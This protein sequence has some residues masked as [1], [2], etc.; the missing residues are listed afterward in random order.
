M[1][2]ERIE[3]FHVAMPLVRPF[4]TSLGAW[5]TV[6]SV[7]V[8]MTSG[9]LSGW[10]ESAPGSVPDYCPEYA[11]GA[12][13][14]IRD[15]LAPRLLG[16]DLA[17]GEQLQQAL[18]GIR[19]NRFAKAALDLAWW[20][21]H[22]RR[23]DRPLWK[24]LGGQS[25][26]VRVGADLGVQDSLERLGELVDAAV[27]DGFPRLKLK[28]EPGRDV[29]VVAAVRETHPDL[30]VHVDGN[31]AYSLADVDLFRRLDD[32]GLA[33]IEQPLANDDLIDHAELRRQVR[34]PICLDESIDS[35]AAAAK[36]I[37]I[38]ACDWINIKHGR[39]GG[40]TAA[41]AIH[42]LC[43]AAGV[44]NW[45][46]GMLESAVGQAFATAL[47]TLDNV[48]Y[49][50]DIFPSSRFYA[51]DLGDPPLV[52][53]GAG[54]AAAAEAPGIAAAPHPARLVER[55]SQHAVIQ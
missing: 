33:M 16:G 21:L 6:E 14:L 27:A 3:L 29:D 8:K 52:L 19:G 54:L 1:R 15:V 5:D 7:L 42:D 45:I 37:R 17:S 20:D 22:A 38:G 49:P 23:L 28:I 11:A 46:G 26:T 35:P 9:G 12:F 32:F 43:R 55:T 41:L 30:T 47:A 4:R 2:I 10:G 48:R 24:L 44:G 39:V 25:P 40:V 50:S 36:A 31:S 51:A 34:T 18:A 53:A 13:A